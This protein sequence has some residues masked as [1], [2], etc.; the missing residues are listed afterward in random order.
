[1]SGRL[2]PGVAVLVIGPTVTGGKRAI[3]H[4]GTVDRWVAENVTLPEWDGDVAA[5][6]GWVVV[7]D[8]PVTWGSRSAHGALGIFPGSS[9]MPLDG[10]AEPEATPTTADKPQPVEA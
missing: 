1:M 10:A 3:G 7:F 2:G 8:R 4:T 6:S 5:G 9:L